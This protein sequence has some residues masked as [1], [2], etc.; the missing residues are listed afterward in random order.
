MNNGQKTLN[1][2]FDGKKIFRI[3]EYQRA[4]AWEDKQLSDFIDDFKNQKIDKDYFFGTILFQEVGKK[5]AYDLIEIVDG[6]QRITTL[7]IFL[8]SLLSKYT[9]CDAETKELYVETYIKYKAAFKLE[10]LFDDNDFFVSYILENSDIPSEIISTPSF[11]EKVALCQTVFRQEVEPRVHSITTQ[12][13]FAES[14]PDKGSY[15]L[16]SGQIRSNANFRN[17]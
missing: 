14:R 3:P 6:Q 4:Y 12:G 8:N 16:C 5:G 13:A 9:D 15:I 17:H 2:L 7:I 10:V 1:D 11:A